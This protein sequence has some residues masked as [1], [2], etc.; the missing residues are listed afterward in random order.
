MSAS[1]P[2]R[3]LVFYRSMVFKYIL[4][5]ML[6]LCLAVVP[7]ALRY[8]QDSRD[9]E[10]RNLASQ[11]EFFAIRG[12]AW[13]DVQAISTLTHPED[14]HTPA[15]HTVLRTLQRIKQDFGVDN[16]IIMRRQPDGRYVF[17][18]AEHDG[19]AIGQPAVI[20]E[21]FPET[22]KATNETWLQG[23]MTHSQLFGGEVNGQKFD[24]FL[25][26]NIPLKL[27]NRVVAILMLNKFA[28]PVAEAVGAKTLR[29]VALTAGLL[30]VGLGLF[31][32]ASAWMLRPLKDLTTAASE[33][34][35]GRLDLTIPAP[36]RQDEVGRLAVTF[37]TMLAGLRQATDDVQATNQLLQRQLCEMQALSDVALALSSTMAVDRLLEMIMDT[38][39]TVMRAEASSLLILDPATN[40]LRFHVAQGMAGET[41]R[42]VT[43]KPGQ[44]VAGWVAQTGEPVLIA[45][46]YQDPHFDPSF[47]QRSGFHT[48]SLIS[49][50]LKTRT[51]ITGVVQVINKIG[52]PS[53][54][55][56][57]LQLFLSF[58]SQASVALENARL[59]ERTRAMAED[60]RQ[61]LEQERR[62]T[63]EKE[64]MGAYIPKQVIDEISRHR[65]QKLALGGKTIYLTILFADIQGFT[66]L[67]EK[68]EPQ[69]VVGFL[70]V[71]MT[72]MTT[73]IE[74]EGGIVDKFIGDGIM[75]I[76]TPQQSR[77]NHALRAVHAGIRMQQK[78]PEL[79][80]CW[81]ESHPEL[82]GMQV[83]V[84]IN[85]GEVVA[86]NIGSE[87]RMDYTV[88]GDNV[89]VAA[90]LE[91]VCDA[92]EVYISESTHAA[93][94][95]CVAAEK[96]QPVMVKN[97]TQPVQ[98]Y[99][100]HIPAMVSV[101]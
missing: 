9:Y 84:G 70:N 85:T 12:A 79:E 46:A 30:V 62:L 88:V 42:T 90:R 68:M 22:Y 19:F 63:I 45:D 25:Q 101:V 99:A 87:T 6:V 3:R 47:D 96:M 18:A 4:L 23:E 26:V 72:A 57:D 66:R 86:G 76:F 5:F 16:A 27:D 29:V 89:N 71:F 49:A 50:P 74:G 55:E 44:G 20:H 97:R 83:R 28:N 54:D 36:R 92:G 2:S 17:V 59:Y 14:K 11:L 94:G 82:L 40:T 10:I 58:A 34:A 98:A 60:L 100:V 69:R 21:W 91:S 75:A 64:K 33:V 51:E 95:G 35:Q 39:K 52:Q 56:H 7:L 43:V 1:P 32:F 37:N 8:D 15:Y 77:D 31:G 13:L 81:S 38:S 73:I 67:A 78:L 80:A 65:E 53:F 93:V 61:A 48:R 24:Q 41:L